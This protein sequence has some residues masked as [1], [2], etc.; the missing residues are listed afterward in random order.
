MGDQRDSDRPERTEV[1]ASDVFED[2]SNVLLLGSPMD[3]TTLRTGISLAAGDR[4]A[5]AR[6]VWVTMLNSSREVLDL[7]DT[8]CSV[9]PDRLRIVLV[10]DGLADIDAVDD[11]GVETDSLPDPTDLTTLGVKLTET[12]SAWTD[13][14]VEVRL[15]FDSLTPLLQYVSART[16]ARFLH[17]LTNKLAMADVPAH[18]HL[19]PMAHDSQ[20]VYTLAS[21][22]HARVE[23]DGDGV[24]VTHR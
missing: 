7:W 15:R 12:V 2:A 9:R 6:V 19:D 14:G 23:V 1:L 22:C 3:D 11:P 10:G 16:L 17:V 4:P 5:E 13:D 24:S 8:H 20:T 18:F 21:V